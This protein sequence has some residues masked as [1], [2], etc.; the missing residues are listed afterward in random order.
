MPQNI[1]KNILNF[2]LK[3][4]IIVVP[5][6][7][8]LKNRVLLSLLWLMPMFSTYAQDQEIKGDSLKKLYHDSYEALERYDYATII[9]QSA[10]LIK[11]A[12]KKQD[13]KYLYRGYQMLGI[14]YQDLEDLKR[15]RE[16]YEKA[17][18]Y[19]LQIPND[20]IL[21]GAY[22]NLGNIFSEDKETVKKGLEYYD[23]AIEYG[24]NIKGFAGILN[25][26]MNKGWT[27]LDNEQ[28]ERA[29]PYLEKA[30][31]LLKNEKKGEAYSQ[32]TTLFGKYFS[33]IGNMAK[34]R[35]Y[36]EASLDLAEKD[37]LIIAASYASEEYAKMLYKSGDYKK[38]Y[39]INSQHQ[40]YQS[41]IMEEEKLH[42]M[43]AAY[44]RFGMEES[45]KKLELAK[46]EQEFKDRV[47]TKT[48]QISFILAIS[49]LIML[50]FLLLLFRNNR[51]RQ[52]LIGQLREKNLEFLAAK[53]KAEKLSMLKTR[54]FS[55]V[56]HELR[57]PL[58]GVVGLTSLLL[59][60][61]P[62]KK[63]V[64]D[65]NSLK[66]SADYLLAL[67][68]DVLQ[69][70]KIESDLV[71]L[72]NIPFRVKDLMNSIIKSF[73]FTRK[74]NN[75]EIVLEI[76]DDVPQVMVGDSVR[77]SQVIM[78]L[79]GNAVKFT[80]RGKVWIKIHL[81]KEDQDKCLL[82]FEVG[83]TG[84]GIPANKQEV[85]FDEFSQLYSNNFS[86]QGTGLGLPIV[87]KLLQ[88]FGS[89]IELKSIEGQ[90]SV[91]NFRIKF[92]KGKPQK[93]GEVTEP[94]FPEE[95]SKTVLIVDDNRINLTVT[96]RVLEKRQFEC[97]VASGG[98]EAIQMVKKGDFD[99]I[100]MDVNMPDIDGMETTRRIRAFNPNVPIIA[101]TAV[102]LEEMIEEILTSGMNDIIIKPYDTNR[103]FSTIYK[104][105]MTAVV[106]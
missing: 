44:A 82:Y 31:S 55:T 96:R 92:E 87:K 73:E 3:L 99:L 21:M 64:E 34:S 11:L 101:L 63:Q 62:N 66:F 80:E 39:E 69:M 74:Q 40:E 23:K 100:L 24:D 50:L 10:Q 98:I 25:P 12:S 4:I 51:I 29:L 48:R 18:E 9:D 54:F 78:N 6:L 19:A 71:Q 33:G 20:T 95:S 43:E 65:L 17:L 49:V 59:E 93:D 68:N 26:V 2:K 103:F 75:N 89:K 35:E 47:I 52:K 45:Q 38:A 58:Y 76:D 41:Q 97:A 77:L 8:E 72:E 42:Q 84:M 79:V 70:N 27:H 91:F 94:I 14:A 61:N 28:Y 36:F 105:L 60:D 88:L 53:E 86:Y 83:D 56:S 104:N 85:I 5:K 90:G 7:H 106:V 81:E 57:T 30:L 67:I 32:L 13:T 16:N 102:E 46:K 37:S 15:A 22:N 1:N